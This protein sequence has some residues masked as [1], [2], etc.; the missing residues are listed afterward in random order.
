MFNF[1]GTLPLIIDSCYGNSCIPI[2]TSNCTTTTAIQ[3][4][5]SNPA[6]TDTLTTSNTSKY[7]VTI[8][9]STTSHSTSTTPPTTTP[10]TSTSLATSPTTFIIK[11]YWALVVIGGVIVA[12][13]F[14]AVITCMIFTGL[15][16]KGVKVLIQYLSDSGTAN[17]ECDI[18]PQ[19]QQPQE[20][21]YIIAYTHPYPNFS[22][23]AY[24]ITVSRIQ[25]PTR[26]HTS[27]P[28]YDSIENEQGIL[29]KLYYIIFVSVCPGLGHSQ[30]GMGLDIPS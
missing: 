15:V 10:G 23:I 24:N 27:E 5:T 8:C 2:I 6:I 3:G 29:M 21:G 18:Q 11:I 1:I 4:S 9:P 12:I 26:Y 20:E 14:I 22:F 25:Y 17:R 30:L 13:L 19:Q 16:A 28:Q 7:P